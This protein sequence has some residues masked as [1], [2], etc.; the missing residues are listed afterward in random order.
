V[1]DRGNRGGYLCATKFR[2]VCAAKK[3]VRIANA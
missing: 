3:G 2:V 1:A